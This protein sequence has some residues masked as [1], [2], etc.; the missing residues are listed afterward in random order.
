MPAAAPFVRWNREVSCYEQ[1][2]GRYL[3]SSTKLLGGLFSDLSSFLPSSLFCLS[4]T[5]CWIC[6]HCYSER[7]KLDLLQFYQ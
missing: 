3:V 1:E 5:Q 6:L 2:Q 7:E 4:Y